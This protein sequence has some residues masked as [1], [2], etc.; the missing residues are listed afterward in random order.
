MIYTKTQIDLLNASLQGDVKAFKKLL[1]VSQKLA[2]LEGAIKSEKKA[3][4]WLM[5]N[6]AILAVFVSATEG[7]KSAIRLLIQKGETVLAATANVLKGD[8]KAAMWLVKHKLAHYIELAEA[9]KYAQDH[10]PD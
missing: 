7:N 8:D 5:K 10:T 4:D 3:M 6:D 9:I 2:A 1:Q